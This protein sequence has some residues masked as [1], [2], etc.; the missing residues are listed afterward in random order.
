MREIIYE[1]I[2]E[3][4]LEI[5]YE[6]ICEI[7][8]EIIYA[9]F[10]EI[11][12]EIYRVLFALLLPLNHHYPIILTSLPHILDIVFARTWFSVMVSEFFC[13]NTISKPPSPLLTPY[14]TY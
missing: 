1:I 9:I 6:I 14:P 7:L 12:Y 4:L 5:V 3:I 13:P 11:V 8:L 2:C 10:Y